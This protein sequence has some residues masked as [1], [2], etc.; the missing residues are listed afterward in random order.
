[1]AFG[2]LTLGIR[3]YHK[4]AKNLG[5]APSGHLFLP[6][7]CVKNDVT[8]ED[9]LKVRVRKHVYMHVSE[10][11]CNSWKKTNNSAE[12]FA[13]SG[14]MFRLPCDQRSSSSL[15]N[16]LCSETEWQII[17]EVCDILPFYFLKWYLAQ[18]SSFAT[19]TKDRL[20]Q[21]CK[22]EPPNLLWH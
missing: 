3:G 20:S 13:I 8:S 11:C 7:V 14:F 9:R 16:E 19:R 21:V 15:I 10:C 1:M 18:I 5:L 17:Q 2:F 6:V 4:D 12:N 22:I